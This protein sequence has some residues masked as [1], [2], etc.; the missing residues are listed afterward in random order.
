LLGN[1]QVRL[2]LV[3]ARLCHGESP[4]TQADRLRIVDAAITK[5]GGTP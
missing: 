5:L 1:E 4:L 3:H 2:G